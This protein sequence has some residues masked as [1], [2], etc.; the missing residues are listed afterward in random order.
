MK[1]ISK[2]VVSSPGFPYNF[3][4]CFRKAHNQMLKDRHKQLSYWAVLAGFVV[5]VGGT[6][7]GQP[8]ASRLI[9][10]SGN[11][12]YFISFGPKVALKSMPNDA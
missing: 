7:T 3:N 4:S 9:E 10:A 8:V 12:F 2:P 6:F 5:V 1:K 11:T